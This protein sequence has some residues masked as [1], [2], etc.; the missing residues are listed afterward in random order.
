MRIQK[1]LV[2]LKSSDLNNEI[3]FDPIYSPEKECPEKYGNT[4]INYDDNNNS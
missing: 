3:N 2:D 4:T 1:K